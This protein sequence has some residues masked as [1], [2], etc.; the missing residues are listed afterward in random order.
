VNAVKNVIS[1]LDLD[2]WKEEAEYFSVMYPTS[3]AE[4]EIQRHSKRIL[5]L[6]KR[7][8]ELESK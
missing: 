5:Q 8:K 4:F 2:K 6:I 1:Q 7:I 3:E